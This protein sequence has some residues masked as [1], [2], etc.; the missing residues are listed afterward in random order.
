MRILLLFSGS[1]LG[2]RANNIAILFFRIAVAI[3]LIVVHGSKKIA[4]H[5]H[6]AEI[7]PNPLGLPE[8]FN[9][10]FAFAATL[11]FP[12]FILVGFYT[13]VAALFALAVPM[14]GYLVVHWNDSLA[15]KDVPF[16]YSISLLLIIVCGAGKYSMDHYLANR[17]LIKNAKPLR[18]LI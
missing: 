4:H 17:D 5:G 16:M 12:L 3:E 2:N 14:T 7:V 8:A 11:I 9:Q 15:E 6:A 1:D 13:R 10:G 18:S